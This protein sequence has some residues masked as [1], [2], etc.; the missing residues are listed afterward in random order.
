MIALLKLLCIY[1]Y[2]MLILYIALRLYVGDVSYILSFHQQKAVFTG[3]SH[4]DE[5]LPSQAMNV[6]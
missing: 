6:F 1:M 4:P 2:A 5:D 3:L